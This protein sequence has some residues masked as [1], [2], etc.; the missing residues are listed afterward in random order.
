[1]VNFLTVR[2]LNYTIK[3]FDRPTFLLLSPKLTKER[4]ATSATKA[5]ERRMFYP[6][7]TSMRRQRPNRLR[8]DRTGRGPPSPHSTEGVL[9]TSAGITRSR[10]YL[11]LA[12]FDSEPRP[13]FA[14]PRLKPPKWVRM[15]DRTLALDGLLACLVRTG[16]KGR[17]SMTPT[18][19]VNDFNS[20]VPQAT[21]VPSAATS[22]ATANQDISRLGRQLN[23]ANRAIC[24]GPCN[25]EPPSLSL[26]R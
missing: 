25:P 22:P 23:S 7:R 21:A 5:I 8:T 24:Q 9:K 3:R 26:N 19:I 10:D 11:L 20:S 14:G 12:D 13:V 15:S 4:T 18:P 6:H 1:M 17:A 2:S 16:T